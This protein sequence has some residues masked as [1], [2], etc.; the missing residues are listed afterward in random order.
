MPEHN[1]R[2][3]PKQQRYLRSLAQGTGTSFTPPQT[4]RE[5]SQEIDR[6]TGL[7]SSSKHDRRADRQAVQQAQ[8][9]G[10]ATVH[11]GEISGWGSSAHWKGSA[12]ETG[13]DS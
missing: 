13:E 7:A 6:L 4:R 1:D 3:T 9:G 5:A 8:R 10:A 2:P 12:L 11:E